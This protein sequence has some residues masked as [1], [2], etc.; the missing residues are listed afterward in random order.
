MEQELTAHF[1][2]PP[3]QAAELAERVLDRAVRL[4]SDKQA[5]AD[6]HGTIA[7]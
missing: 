1:H 2:L 4:I 6:Q 5:R 7:S 3:I